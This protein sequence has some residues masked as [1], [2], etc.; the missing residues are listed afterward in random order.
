[1]IEHP[2]LYLEQL[3]HDDVDRICAASLQVLD[4][5]GMCIQS[6]E[7]CQALADAGARVDFATQHVRFPPDLVENFLA[8]APRQWV[9]AARNPAR[10]VTI[11]GPSTV[12]APGYGAAFVADAA[13]KRRPA[14]MEDFRRF[15]RLAQACDAVDIGGGL[16]VE[17]EDVAPALR[18]LEQCYALL[19]ATDKPIMGSVAGR[20][21]AR[22]SLD[23]AR[24]VFRRRFR[25]PVILALINI[26]SPLRLDPRMADAMIEYVRAGQPVLL[27]PGIMMG[28][29]APVTVAGA[30][31]QAFA[32]LM[33]CVA[34][35]QVVRPGAPVIVGLG[36]FGADLRT[37]G[38][39]FGRPE[40]ALATLLGAQLA[41]KL[42]LPFRCSAAVTGARRPDCR[43]GYERMMT[44]LAAW[45]GGAHLALQ[46]AGIL[47]CIN[48][49]SYEQF[50]IDAEIWSYIK[51]LAAR[52]NLSDETLALEII[53]QSQGD[54][55]SHEHTLRHM[56]GELYTPG[57]AP[58]ETYEDWL[59]AEGKDAAAIAREKVERFTA[60]PDPPMDPA[61][62]EELD[63]YV[64]RRRRELEVG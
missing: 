43:S 51:R 37:G 3:G 10:D 39:G 40:N 7:A 1:M 4:S 2:R 11:G 5:R 25:N 61:L 34:L 52:T 45:M 23:M 30:L 26:N 48:T 56:R 62:R 18:P 13:G 27:T 20:D 8:R 21:G 50:V 6:R 31:V 36:G 16:L 12:V 17:P 53:R 44:A 19:T 59:G 60:T 9:L 29:T 24:I 57:L 15:V 22:E 63:S 58:S 35:A 46:A 49:M 32:E 38:S 41:R 42:K 47:D 55:L 33:G 14:R 64:A 28:M 54:Y